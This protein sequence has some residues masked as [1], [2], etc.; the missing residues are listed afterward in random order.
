MYVHVDRTRKIPATVLLRALGW[1]STQRIME[2]FGDND[3]IRNTLEKDNTNS[4]EEALVEI[5]KRLRPGEP[6]AVD[7]AR[8]LFESLFFDPKSTTWPAWADTSSTA[9]WSWPTGHRP[10]WR[11]PYSLRPELRSGRLV[12]LSP[13]RCSQQ[14][15]DPNTGE[16]VDTIQLMTLVGDG[17]RVTAR[18]AELIRELEHQRRLFEAHVRVA[19]TIAR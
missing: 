18:K 17:E 9:S 5:Y 19:T 8:S 13:A 2:L 11:G 4:Q 3:F 10:R 14:T 16:L 15:L 7:S 6:P 1:G 12:I